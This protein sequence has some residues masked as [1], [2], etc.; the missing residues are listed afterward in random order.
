M[1]GFAWSQCF[2]KSAALSPSNAAAFLR[3]TTIASRRN[4]RFHHHFTKPTNGF[5]PSSILAQLHTRPASCCGVNCSTRSVAQQLNDERS[6]CERDEV[7]LTHLVQ[8]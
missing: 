5:S 3:P 6:S 8:G 1:L 7:F 2:L 4:P